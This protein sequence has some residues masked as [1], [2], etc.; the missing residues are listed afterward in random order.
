[1]QSMVDVVVAKYMRPEQATEFMEYLLRLALYDLEEVW[2]DECAGLEQRVAI[3]T[4]T[5]SEHGRELQTLR[6]RFAQM[7]MEAEP[8]RLRADALEA[9]NIRLKAQMQAQET[10]IKQAR[11]RDDLLR[12]YNTE[13]P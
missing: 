5:A 10:G 1:M 11:T 12:L 9:E 3:A 6:G 2:A 13:A 8:Q 4:E 7:V